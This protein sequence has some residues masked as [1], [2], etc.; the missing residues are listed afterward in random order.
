LDRLGRDYGDF[1]RSL[2]LVDQLLQSR[3]DGFS[4][5][6][7]TIVPD[8]A[9]LMRERPRVHFSLSILSLRVLGLD[10]LTLTPIKANGLSFR[11]AR[12][13]HIDRC[14]VPFRPYSGNRA[15]SLVDTTLP[16]C[17]LHRHY[18][19]CILHH[20]RVAVTRLAGF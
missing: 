3:V 5:G 7:P 12:V 8:H 19:G 2:R 6:A 4:P 18:F 13:G 10:S 11:V 1:F 9:L 17:T 15:L 14:A 16:L 20:R